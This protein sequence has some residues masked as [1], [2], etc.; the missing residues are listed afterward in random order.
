MHRWHEVAILKVI[1]RL[2]RGNLSTGQSTAHV[3]IHNDVSNL[4]FLSFLFNFFFFFF[5]AFFKFLFATVLFS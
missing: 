5:C 2:Y 1:I 4:S 3:N